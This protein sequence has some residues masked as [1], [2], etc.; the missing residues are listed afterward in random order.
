MKVFW[1]NVGEAVRI[2]SSSGRCGVS[3][4]L[5]VDAAFS[6]KRS[7]GVLWL[8]GSRHDACFRHERSADS[9]DSVFTDLTV[10]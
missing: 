9:P 2:V 5:H 8:G 4:Q 1:G 6:W 3:G 7:A 10:L